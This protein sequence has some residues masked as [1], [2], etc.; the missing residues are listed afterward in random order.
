VR[1]NDAVIPIVRPPTL[2]L[3]PAPPRVNVR[4]TR[5]ENGFHGRS[6]EP[7]ALV[8]ADVRLV[9][10]DEPRFLPIRR[11]RRLRREG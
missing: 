4:I 3:L 9:C 10:S 6:G 1:N 7:L 2:P 5:L 8:L 11:R